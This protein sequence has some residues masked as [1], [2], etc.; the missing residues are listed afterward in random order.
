MRR[1]LHLLLF[2]TLACSKPEA[3]QAARDEGPRP[4]ILLVTLDTTRFD[5]IGTNTP[6]FNALVARGRLFQHAYAT[7]PHTLPSHTSMLT[8]LYPA[9]HGVHENSRYLSASQP[10]AAERLHGAGYHTGAFVSAYPLSK[11]FGLSR[12]FEVYDDELGS[13]EGRERPA[14]ETTDRALAWLGRQS[15]G[16]PLFLWVH[17]FEPHYPYEPPAGF[18]DRASAYLGEI[19]AMDAQLGRLVAAFEKHAGGPA[20]ILV[21]GD[22]GEGLGDHGESQHGKLLY[23]S[24]MRVPMVLVG[25]GIAPS[26]WDPPVSTRRVFHTLLDYGGIAPDLSLRTP[27]TEVVAGEAMAPFL[28]HGWQPQVMAVDGPIKAIQAG[29]VE[30][31]DVDA[32]PAERKDLGGGASLSRELR[33]TLV[34]YPIP[35]LE[36]PKGEAQI[37]GEDRRQL[38]SLGYVAS[39]VRPVVRK[40]APRPRDMT[41][42]FDALSLASGLFQREKYAEAIPVLQGILRKD[43]GNLMSAIQLASA[44]SVTGRSDQALVSF[45]KAQE[46]A[47]KSV[48][49][50]H[51]LGLHYLRVGD[52]GRAAPLMESVVAA[53]P[54]RVTALEALAL[55]RVRQHRSEEALALWQRVGA[56]RDLTGVEQA[57]IGMAAME[58]G[59]TPV[60]LAAFERA[61]ALQGPAFRNHLELGALYMA[62]ER[63]REAAKEFDLV[64]PSDPGAPM[65]LFKRAQL[66]VLLAEPDAGERIARARKNADANT[67]E[68]VAREPLFHGK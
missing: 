26:K 2:L 63:Y 33:K 46:I 43:P 32:D 59:R 65:A 9:G 34:E 49:V 61:A 17:Y 40:D 44:Q 50:S 28:Q 45:R 4:S 21:T 6:S 18:R 14:S 7:A 13:G 52:I 55:I 53:E 35:S 57:R 42:L 64:P 22:H 62:R 19:A 68:L 12:G 36:P 1:S 66:S 56:A 27:A 48:D 3:P 39:D 54:D 8:G 38:A 15:G 60:A 41:A 23:Q 29:G 30:V 24:V 37:T 10:L 51:Y 58:L 16:D 31:Y 5:A 20:V 11:P 25:P 67:R 47:P